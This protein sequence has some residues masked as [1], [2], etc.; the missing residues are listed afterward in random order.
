MSADRRGAKINPGIFIDI[1]LSGALMI[2]APAEF[3]STF[4]VNCKA[5]GP[6]APMYVR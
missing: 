3:N 6:L 4:D 2:D 5:M 1:L